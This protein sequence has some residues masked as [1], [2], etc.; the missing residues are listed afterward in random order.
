MKKIDTENNIVEIG[1]KEDILERRMVAKEV[2]YVSRG[3]LNPGDIVYGKIRYADR[4][5]EAVVVESDDTAF[6]VDFVEPK[7]AI[8]PGQ[9]AV[10]YDK[11]GYVLAGGIITL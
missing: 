10:L 3:N 6:T 11:N 8:T 1:D 7:S 4:M 9:S 2:N 5:T